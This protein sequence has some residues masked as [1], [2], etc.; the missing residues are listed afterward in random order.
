MQGHSNVVA[1]CG[2]FRQ[3][4]SWALLSEGGAPLREATA[5]GR[6]SEQK[7]R[8]LG[9]GQSRAACRAQENS[10]SML[11]SSFMAEAGFFH[12]KRHMGGVY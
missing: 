2:L 5:V 12:S 1:L 9:A 10:S 6:C 8:R 11:W 3:A 7:T 4:D